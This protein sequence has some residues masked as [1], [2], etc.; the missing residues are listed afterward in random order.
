LNKVKIL[1]VITRLNIGGPAQHA[2]LLSSCMKAEDFTTTLITG[3]CGKD[4]GNMSYFAEQLG[5]KPVLV[6]QMSREVNTS[7]DFAALCRIYKIIKKEKPDIVHTHTAKAG[8]LGRLA[9]MLAG[10]SIRVHTF[11]GHSLEKYFGKIQST[12]FTLIERFLGFFTHKIIAISPEQLKDLLVKHRIAGKSKFL[13]IELGLELDS[14]FR[15]GETHTGAFRKKYGISENEILIGIIA[16]LVEIKNHKFF[17]DAIKTVEKDAREKKY[18]FAIIGDG[19]LK[20]ELAL[21]AEKL[22]IDDLVV[23]TGWHKNMKEIYEALDIVV[24]SS[25]NEGTPVSLIEALASARPVVATD[26][27]GVRNVVID[28]ENGYVVAQD[29]LAGFS[30][31]I[32]DLA[33]DKEKR[34]K[35]GIAGREYVRERFSAARLASDMEKLYMEL[36]KKRK[37]A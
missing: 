16:R 37:V 33:Q 36:L 28:G 19:K 30:S 27:G 11:H 24:L 20:E 34:K 15:I 3:S 32:L 31:K 6:G 21:Y 10:G 35:F 17:L 18:K 14:F 5:V 29:D 12:F 7:K 8:T 2:V 13:V 1:R 4:E 22:R 26:A 23:F 9:S 25:K